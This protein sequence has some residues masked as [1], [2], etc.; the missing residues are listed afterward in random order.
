MNSADFDEENPPAWLYW[1]NGLELFIDV[2]T[3]ISAVNAFI[4]FRKKQLLHEN[5]VSLI[6]SLYIG[7]VLHVFSGTVLCIACFVYPKM[8]CKS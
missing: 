7:Y 4:I 6:F 8:L 2:L 3:L 5:L 1:E